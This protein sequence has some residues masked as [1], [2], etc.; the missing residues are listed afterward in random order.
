MLKGRVAAG[1]DSAKTVEAL[2]HGTLETLKELHAFINRWNHIV[3][4]ESVRI[5]GLVDA[6]LAPIRRSIMQQ[7]Q[8]LKARSDK[9][10]ARCM[11]VLQS[12]RLLMRLVC[13]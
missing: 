7:C 12:R 1:E 10:Y 6:E 5:A 8:R 3:S 11:S 4:G 2:D 13:L 9:L